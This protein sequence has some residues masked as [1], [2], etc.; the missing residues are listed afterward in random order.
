MPPSRSGRIRNATA[1]RRDPKRHRPPPGHGLGGL[2]GLAGVFRW[3]NG[4]FSEWLTWVSPTLIMLVVSLSLLSMKPTRRSPRPDGAPNNGHLLTNDHLTNTK[5]SAG[6]GSRVIDDLESP[7]SSEFLPSIRGGCPP[8]RLGT[9]RRILSEAAS[10]LHGGRWAGPEHVLLP[11]LAGITLLAPPSRPSTDNFFVD[12]HGVRRLCCG[13]SLLR[14]HQRSRLSRLLPTNSQ[15][16]HL[17]GHHVQGSSS[18]FSAS[19]WRS[20]N[21]ECRIRDLLT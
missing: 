12:A 4:G 18:L 13:C 6:L 11:L 9:A 7:G 17:R 16:P 5:S 3:G 20:T 10:A 2:H 1:P 21:T 8:L 19:T 15:F 14:M